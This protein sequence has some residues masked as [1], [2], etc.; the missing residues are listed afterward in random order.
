MQTD[1]PERMSLVLFSGTADKLT[2]AGISPKRAAYLQHFAR[3]W[4]GELPADA[5][6]PEGSD[7]EGWN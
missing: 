1:A 5:T 6:P 7:D 4:L 2:A 3:I